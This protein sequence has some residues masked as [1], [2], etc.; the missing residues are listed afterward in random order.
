MSMTQE[1]R[2]EYNRQRQAEWRVRQKSGAPAPVRKPTIRRKK[3]GKLPS[4]ANYVKVAEFT[5]SGTWEVWARRREVSHKY[6]NLKVIARHVPK[7]GAPVVWVGYR[8]DDDQ[9]RL[10]KNTSIDT[11]RVLNPGLEQ[12]IRKVVDSLA[13]EDIPLVTEVTEVTKRL[14]SN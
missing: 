1:E 6:V 10:A 14:P 13:L 5:H 3:I 9:K 11:M 7:I 4:K 8:V 2:R 12:E